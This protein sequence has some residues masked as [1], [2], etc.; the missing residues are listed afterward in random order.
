[1]C[2]QFVV[3]LGGTVESY[4][5]VEL[6]EIYYETYQELIRFTCVGPLQ[7][8]SDESAIESCWGTENST[9]DLTN[10]T[11][12]SRVVHEPY[13]WPELSNNLIKLGGT[14]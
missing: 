3:L 8:K 7:L 5:L 12:E 4:W 11:S 6:N 2:A 13:P 14:M 9:F 10:S 1:V